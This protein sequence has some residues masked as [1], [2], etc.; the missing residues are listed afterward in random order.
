MYIPSPIPLVYNLV[1]YVKTEYPNQISTTLVMSVN[2]IF[3]VAAFSCVK[4]PHRP[5]A[6]HRIPYQL[7]V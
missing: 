2:A 1:G 6:N 7:Y 5:S 4:L 3:A